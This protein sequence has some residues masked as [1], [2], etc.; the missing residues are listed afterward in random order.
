MDQERLREWIAAHLGRP[1][2]VIEDVRA[3]GGGSIQENRLVRC[4]IAGEERGFVLRMDAPATIASSRSRAEEFCILETVWKA[5]VRVPEPV[6]F[7]NDPAVIGAPFALMGLVEGVGLG[8]RIAKDLTLGGDREHLTEAL[9]RELAKI[10]AALD[11]GTPPASLAF[12]GAPEPNPARAEV[13]RLRASLDGIGALRPAIEWGLRWG[14]LRAPA[15][16]APTLVHR[17]FRTGNYMVDANG[18]TAV[19]DWEFAGWGDPAQDLGWF[20]A[21]C[22]RFG[23]PELE[24]GGIGSR[25]AFYRGYVEAGG[26]PIDPESV[27]YW[28]VMAHLRWAV[29]ALEQGTRHVSGREFSLELALTGR[30]VPELERAILRATAPASWS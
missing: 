11:P 18:L 15:C 16:P 12:L 7:C 17:D 25:A 5:G 1:D 22:W 3:L 8:P 27:A 20:C 13:A 21:A 28:E 2:L 4:R 10:H 14:E 23:R 19:L 29:I 24:A 6:G 26:R 9:G 30:M